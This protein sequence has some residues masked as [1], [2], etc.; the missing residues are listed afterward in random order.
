MQKILACFICL[1]FL[2]ASFRAPG[3][4]PSG[5]DVPPAKTSDAINFA[6]NLDYTISMIVDEYVRPVSRND[7][8]VAALT[9]LYEAAQVPVPASLRA[10]VE[11][12][13]ADSDR[14]AFLAEDPHV[15][16]YPAGTRRRI[17]G[18]R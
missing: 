8:M 2:V 4:G 18:P 6:Q 10:D 14:V 12:A 13:K 3:N 11:K 9:G 15:A 7:L 17:F 1:T 16:D 5:S